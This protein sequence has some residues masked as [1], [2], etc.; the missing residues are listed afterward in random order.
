MNRGS[1]KRNKSKNV[2]EVESARLIKHAYQLRTPTH[3][4]KATSIALKS[5]PVRHNSDCSKV[6][7]RCTCNRNAIS[8]IQGCCFR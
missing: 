7:R 2:D 3:S 8:L 6:Q 4:S 5:V 1:G